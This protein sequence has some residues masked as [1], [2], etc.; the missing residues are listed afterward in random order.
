MFS[1]LN[2]A[3]SSG[4]LKQA[5]E[6]RLL[7]HIF[8]FSYNRLSY[9]IR[10]IFKLERRILEVSHRSIKVLLQRYFSQNLTYKGLLCLEILL[11]NHGILPK[12][13]ISSAILKRL[14]CFQKGNN[15]LR[16][17]K[18]DTKTLY[19]LFET[20]KHSSPDILMINNRIDLFTEYRRFQRIWKKGILSAE[21]IMEFSGISTGP[22]LGGIISSIRRAEFMG[23]I[24][25]KK[26]AKELIQQFS[27]SLLSNI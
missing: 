8:P 27:D 7:K 4:Y 18:K 22:A 26:Q 5:L 23:L 6:D 25:T 16:R 13:Q 3:Y 20:A 17:R 12:L 11:I 10:G 14:D 9:K 21:E 19:H 15:Y 1:L 2:S 24:R